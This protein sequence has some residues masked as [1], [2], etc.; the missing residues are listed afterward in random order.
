[1]SVDNASGQCNGQAD[2]PYPGTG[3]NQPCAFNDIR[4]LWADGAYTGGSAFPGWG[5]IINGGDTVILRNGPW[6]VGYSGPGSHDYF[7]GIAGDP[8]SSG[9]PSIPS[10]TASQPTR[11]LG[12]N[13]AN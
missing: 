12:E 9:A 10:G 11:I 8:Y 7:L 4:Y 13:Y 2:A 6:R 5:W 1:Y 3:V